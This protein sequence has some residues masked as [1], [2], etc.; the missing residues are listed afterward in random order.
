MTVMMMMMMMMMGPLRKK[1]VAQ[2]VLCY[3]TY[4]NVEMIMTVTFVS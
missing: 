3:C 4:C 1:L 2:P